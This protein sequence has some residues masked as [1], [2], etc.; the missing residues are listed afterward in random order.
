MVYRHSRYLMSILNQD[1]LRCCESSPPILTDRNWFARAVGRD[2]VIPR[3]ESLFP[4][5]TLPP[6][7]TGKVSFGRPPPPSRGC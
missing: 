1:S 3:P 2:L 6:V 4:K 7:I 5:P